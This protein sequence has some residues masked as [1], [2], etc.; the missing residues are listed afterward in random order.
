[1]ICESVAGDRC[2]KTCRNKT[3]ETDNRSVVTQ[4]YIL[5]YFSPVE[6]GEYKQRQTSVADEE[7]KK[8]YTSLLT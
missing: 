7:S 5:R 6:L 8:Q 4:L 1:M 3:I 2:H